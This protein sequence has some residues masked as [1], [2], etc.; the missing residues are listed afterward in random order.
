M[1]FKN[2]LPY[3]HQ[4]YLKLFCTFMLQFTFAPGSRLWVDYPWIWMPFISHCP[5]YSG[6]IVP[7]QTWKGTKETKFIDRRG[8]L[9]FV[10]EEDHDFCKYGLDILSSGTICDQFD[11]STRHLKVFCFKNNISIR[12][13][14]VWAFSRNSNSIIESNYADI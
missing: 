14:H 7:W 2:F 6:Q 4:M 11:H 3:V 1:P 8:Q 10:P 5:W 12:K 9:I 13:V